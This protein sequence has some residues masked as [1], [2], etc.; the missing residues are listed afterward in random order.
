MADED[1][2]ADVNEDE[3]E[4]ED[5]EGKSTAVSGKK[6]L[7]IIILAGALLLVTIIIGGLYFSG[8]FNSDLSVDEPSVEE[9]S[10]EETSDVEQSLKKT[11]VEE[12]SVVQEGKANKPSIIK[13][14]F[15]HKFEDLNVNLVSGIRTPRFL[16]MSMTVAVTQEAD[17]L[18]METLTPRVMDNVIQYL[19]G[20]KPEELAGSANFHKM[21]DNVL[22]RIRAAVAPVL[23]TDALITLALVK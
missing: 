21:H 15:Y 18:V 17:V 13:G 8:F 19:N 14:K 7:I 6:R 20:L 2:E 11:S 1:D 10:V 9:P 23:V 5:G 16:R 22:L 12:K 4:G 3:E